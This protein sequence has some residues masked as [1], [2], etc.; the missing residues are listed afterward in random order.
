MDNMNNMDNIGDMNNIYDMDEIAELMKNVSREQIFKLLMRNKKAYEIQKKWKE[1]NKAKVNEYAQKYFKEKI[2]ESDKH[3]D[4][5][6]SEA[7]K[8]TVKKY[9]D[10][11]RLNAKMAKLKNGNL[12]IEAD[13]ANKNLN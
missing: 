9:N 11:R 1:N 6:K 4:Y 8:A 2:K 13:N 10:K 7:R 5:L 12:N 3:K